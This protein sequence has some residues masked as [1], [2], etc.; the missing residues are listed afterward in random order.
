MG[1]TVTR[2][3]PW[4]MAHQ[5][6]L[7]LSKNLRPA[8]IAQIQDD[9]EFIVKALQDHIDRQD[10]PWKPLARRTI[11]LKNGDS[12]IWIEHGVLRDS[13]RALEVSSKY[14]AS[15]YVTA[16]GNN[17]EGVP[18]ERIVVWL[19]Y[20]TRNMPPRAL[21]RPTA[22]EVAPLLKNHWRELMKE[23]IRTGGK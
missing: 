21:F 3:G 16:E 23:L 2:T 19:E 4:E 18:L 11:E 13:F 15:I 5:T 12:R 7:G 1:F 22:E 8:F 9:G 14:T 6:L 17:D 20:G 10:M